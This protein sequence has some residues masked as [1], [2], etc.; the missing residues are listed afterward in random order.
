ML[1]AFACLSL[2]AQNNNMPQAAKA[3]FDKKAEIYFKTHLQSPDDIRLLTQYMSID[4]ATPSG[5][6]VYVYANQKGFN[7]FLTLGLPYEILPSPGESFKNYKMYAGGKDDFPWDAYPTYEA[8]IAKMQKFATDH[9]DICEV[10]SI[11]QSEQ[12]REIMMAKI[13][14]NVAIEEAE[15]KFLYTGQIHGDEIVAY[16]MFLHLI[17]EIVENYGTDPQITRLVNE[18]EIWINPLSNPDG[19]YITGNDNVYGATRANANGVDMNRNYPCAIKGPHYDGEEYQLATLLFMQLAE[20]NHFVMSSNSH[21]GTEV[22]NYPWDSRRTNYH[23][24]TDWW[25]LV[26][27]EYADT[28]IYYAGS[29]PYFDGFDDGVTHGATWYTVYGGRQD[30]MNYYHHCR[31]LTLELSDEKGLPASQLIDHWNYNRNAMLNYIE[32]AT[33]GFRGQVTDASTNQPIEA[34]VELL[35]HD[36]DNSFVYSEPYFG[37]YYRPV[38]AGT[39]DIRISADCYEPVV[40]EDVNIDNFQVVENNVALQSKAISADFYVADTLVAVGSMLDFENKSCDNPDSYAWVFEGGTPATS[41]EAN[42][43]VI[44]NTEGVYSVSLSVTKNGES[45]T[46][47]RENYIQ[48][49]SPL[50]ITEGETISCNAIFLDSGGEDGNYSDGEDKVMTIKAEEDD[51]VSAL[52][53]KFIEF[54]VEVHSSCNYDYLKIYD[55]ASTNATLLGTYCGSE[56]PGTFVSTNTDKALTFKFHSDNSTAGTGWKAAVSCQHYDKVETEELANIMR[57]YPN[58]ADELINIESAETIEFITLLNMAGQTILSKKAEDAH[59][60]IDVQTLPKGIYMLNV[61]TSSG[62]AN[63]K[64]QVL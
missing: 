10:F 60:S 16:M 15:P 56:L 5:S 53:V 29:Y 48:V 8:Y 6:E 21:S 1:M 62:V 14:D 3:V 45:Y 41:T 22:V 33:Y 39:Y 46:V 28:A 58:P 19:T 35:N 17:D 54:D 26:S 36:K 30:Y 61:H 52:E 24:D 11:G 43:K 59:L 31:E 20:D 49:A 38:V 2:M 34:K 51:N 18:M 47:E 7:Y 40:I 27:H 64:I 42:P 44:Y 25:E 50:V 57:V 12:G 32:Q 9:P 37:M 23:A 13:S 55:G 63:K 4:K